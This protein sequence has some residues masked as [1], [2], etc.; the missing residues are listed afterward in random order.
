MPPAITSMH[1]T[2]VEQP[3]HHDGFYEEKVDGYR[4]LAHKDGD[5]VRLI[6]RHAKDLTARFPEL[7]EA[8]VS[9]F[10]KLAG[11]LTTP[12]KRREFAWRVEYPAYG[13]GGDCFARV[14]L[15]QY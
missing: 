15:R 12:K 6:S 11:L 8:R 13:H 10:L 5:R 4:V 3:F 2:E 9:D 1:P 14:R 7:V